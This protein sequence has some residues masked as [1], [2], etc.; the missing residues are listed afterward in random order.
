MTSMHPHDFAIN[1]YLDGT[2]DPVVAAATV[3][4][5]FERGRT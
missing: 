2:L 4:V 5:G 3:A 1:E